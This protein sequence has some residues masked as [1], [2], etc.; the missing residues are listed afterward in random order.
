MNPA[1]PYV[2]AG[3]PPLARLSGITKRF[4]R[5]T[6]ERA[7]AEAAAQK[8]LTAAMGREHTSAKMPDA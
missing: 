1:P 4:G 2:Q 3:P 8:I 5:V 6:G 7:R